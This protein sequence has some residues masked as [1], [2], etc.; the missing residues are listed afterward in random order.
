MIGQLIDKLIF[1]AALLVALQIPLLADH[2]QQFLSGFYEATKC[3]VERYEA[4]ARQYNYPSV[5][6]M[7]NHH[8]LNPEPSVRAD[9][10]QKRETI[11][12]LQEISTGITAFKS[13]NMVPKVI[14]MFHPVRYHYLKKTLN[15]FKPGFPLT[16]N[17]LTFGVIVGLLINWIVLWPFILIRRLA[18]KRL[19]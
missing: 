6:A 17:G 2:Y 5:G 15:N 12:Q 19:T 10:Q 1:G 18:Q 8:L 11:Q 9:A 14:Y 3:Q 13:G 4:T 16:L 7:I